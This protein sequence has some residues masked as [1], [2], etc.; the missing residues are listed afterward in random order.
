MKIINGNR[1][2]EIGDTLYYPY[3]DTKNKKYIIEKLVVSS[4][5]N[6]ITIFSGSRHY[7]KRVGEVYS[8][9]SN[10]FLSKEEALAYTRT[11]PLNF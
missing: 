1:Y 10:L 6:G 3:P 2:Y 4:T 9:Y 8:L 5:E 7:N 11:N